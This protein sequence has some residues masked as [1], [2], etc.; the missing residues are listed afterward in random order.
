MRMGLDSKGHGTGHA[1]E[2]RLWILAGNGRLSQG[3]GKPQE[4]STAASESWL[5]EA[6]NSASVSVTI[7]WREAQK[8]PYRPTI[9]ENLQMIHEAIYEYTGI[10]EI[11]GSIWLSIRKQEI[12]TPE[13]HIKHWQM[14]GQW[15]SIG[16][17][18]G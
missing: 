3:M 5:L 15:L 1:W 13:C 8:Y 10:L 12:Q 4:P 6:S 18:I 11:D 2:T 7:R 14:T 9:G 17:M 16:L